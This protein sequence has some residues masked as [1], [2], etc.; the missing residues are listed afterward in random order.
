MRIGLAQSLWTP[1][2]IGHAQERAMLGVVVIG[3]A[4]PPA[5]VRTR[6]RRGIGGS[7]A[8]ATTLCR[9]VCIIRR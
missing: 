9:K 6:R 2:E 5:T 3:V 1:D 7:S 8:G 4:V